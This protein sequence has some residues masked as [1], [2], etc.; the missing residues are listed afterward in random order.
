M[1]ASISRGKLAKSGLLG[2]SI[3]AFVGH[4][5]PVTNQIPAPCCVAWCQATICANSRQEPS[6]RLQC[7]TEP[8]QVGQGIARPHRE[9]PLSYDNHYLRPP[10]GPPRRHTPKCSPAARRD[11]TDHGTTYAR[12]DGRG[13]VL[14]A[15]CR[16]ARPLAMSLVQEVARHR[17]RGP[18][19]PGRRGPR[20]ATQ[21]P[22]SFSR[23]QG[24]WPR[25][26]RR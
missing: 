4:L 1:S 20:Y 5:V 14:A 16:N 2:P 26:D 7:R 19:V 17:D 11:P 3:S 22:W 23:R 6:R 12:R 9:W 24:R 15:P 8:E 13:L 21:R 10:V 25:L 18:H